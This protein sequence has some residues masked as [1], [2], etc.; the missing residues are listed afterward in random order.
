M[1]VSLCHFRIRNFASINSIVVGHPF[2]GTSI[3]VSSC[4]ATPAPTDDDDDDDGAV[5]EPIRSLYLPPPAP[6]LLGYRRAMPSQVSVVCG[7][8]QPASQPASTYLGGCNLPHSIVKIR[9]VK[10]GHHFQL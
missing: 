7:H 10:W 3:Y 8:H 2:L 4:A 1:T 5:E 6:P 9:Q